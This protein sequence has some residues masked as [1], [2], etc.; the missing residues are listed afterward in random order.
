MQDMDRYHNVVENVTERRKKLLKHQ[1]ILT[2]S[3]GLVQN[4]GF[5]VLWRFSFTVN[6]CICI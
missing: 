5:T 4:A 1:D 6:V 2:K 3:L